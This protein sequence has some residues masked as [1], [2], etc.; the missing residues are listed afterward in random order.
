VFSSLDRADVVLKPGADG[1]QQFVQTDHRTSEEI[2]Q[3]P[4]LSTLFALVRVLNPKRMAKASS[5]EPVVIYSAQHRPP[6]F[7]RR[8]IRAAGGQLTI[9][10]RTQPEPE[11]GETAPLEEVIGSA[12]TNLARTVAA[13]YRVELNAAGLEKIE[14]AL[15][16]MAGDP[17]ENEFA[18]WSAVVKLGSFAGELIRALNGGRWV[19]VESGSLPFGLVTTFQGE[20]A[21]VNPLGKAIK[22][23]ANGEEDSVGFLVSAACSRP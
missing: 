12:F 16:E 2:E 1:R 7:L 4:E 10:L 5:T 14:E 6:E 21:T 18:Y 15:S 9:G 17:E 8:A 3:A 23:F 13:E 22:R 19:V 20:Q 11:E